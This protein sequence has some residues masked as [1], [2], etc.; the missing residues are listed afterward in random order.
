M[1]AAVAAEAAMA[2]A[3]LCEIDNAMHTSHSKAVQSSFL[4]AECASWN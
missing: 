4:L 3:F 2:T 1:A